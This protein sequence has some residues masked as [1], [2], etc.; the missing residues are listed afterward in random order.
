MPDPQ[1]KSKHAHAA[2]Q[3]QP[4]PRKVRFN[5]GSQYQVLDVVGEGAY[6]IVCSAIHRPSGRKVAI[7][8]I[9]PFDHSMFCLRTLREL[10]LLKFL[11]ESG[12]SENYEP[13]VAI[14][15][16]ISILDIIRPPSLEAFKEVYLIQEL[17]ETDMHRVIRTQDLSDDHAQ[18]FIY[19]TLRALKALHS[20][21]VIHRDLK[22]SNLLLNA[23]CDLKVCDFGLARSVKTAE[24]S[25]TETGFMTEYVAT[26]WYRAPEIMLTFKQYTKAI[27]VWSV[28]CIL[29][30]ML[31][32]KPLF[33]GRD[34]HHQLTLILD[35]LGTPTLDEFYAIT[36]RRSR[37]YI[38]ALPFRKKRPFAAL[39]PNANPLAIDFLTKT[40]TFDP[41]KRITVE[42]AL[43]HPYLEAYHDPEDEPEAPP[44]D[45]EFFE[46][47]LHKDDISPPVASGPSYP[48]ALPKFQQ[49]TSSS[50]FSLNINS[51]AYNYNFKGK[52]NAFFSQHKGEKKTLEKHPP[53]NGKITSQRRKLISDNIKVMK[54]PV[55]EKGISCRLYR[56]KARRASTSFPPIPPAFWLDGLVEQKVKDG[57]EVVR[58]SLRY[59]FSDSR[60]HPVSF[61]R[62]ALVANKY[63]FQLVTLGLDHHYLWSTVNWTDEN[64]IERLYSYVNIIV[65]EARRQRPESIPTLLKVIEDK[66]KP[67]GVFMAEV[68]ED[69]YRLLPSFCGRGNGRKPFV[70][71]GVSM[72][73]K[74]IRAFKYAWYGKTQLDRER[75]SLETLKD[76]PGVVRIDS[77]L[78]QRVLEDNKTDIPG[79]D[80]DEESIRMRSLLV[81]RTVGY[82]CAL[83]NQC[84]SSWRQCTIFSK[85]FVSLHKRRISCIAISVGA[86]FCENDWKVRIALADFDHSV[87]LE[88]YDKYELKNATGTPMF[89]AEDVLSVRK[90]KAMA[91]FSRISR[92]VLGQALDD[93]VD[94]YA[95]HHEKQEWDKFYEK[96]TALRW[97][98][99]P[100]ED[101]DNALL[102]SFRH[103][104]V[105][106][107]ESVVYLCLLFFNRL[108][109]F[110]EY[111]ERSEIGSLEENRG[112]L[113]EIFAGRRC[114]RPTV[115]F[116][117]PDRTSIATG[118]RFEPAYNMLK[119]M[120]SYVSFPWYNV[121]ETGRRERYEFHLHDFMQRLILKEIRRLRSS[122][123]PIFIEENPL[124]ITMPYTVPTY[125]RYAYS[126]SSFSR[127]SESV[128]EVRKK[129]KNGAS[130]LYKGRGCSTVQE[131]FSARA[132][133]VQNDTENGMMNLT[134]GREKNGLSISSTPNTLV[135]PVDRPKEMP[136]RDKEMFH[137]PTGTFW[138]IYWWKARERLWVTAER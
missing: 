12:V 55:K 93:C 18:Y 138:E 57:K 5:V 23:N 110:D 46:F 135:L 62:H 87:D 64:W 70:A 77:S 1:Q 117:L 123:D 63:H 81:L 126:S 89:M 37:D 83:A 124:P 68:G 102:Q 3:G 118:Q 88:K 47:D 60:H 43:A 16:I 52:Y 115:R 34:Y 105:H 45:P 19:Q 112:K 35:V 44:L 25:G 103:G 86:M 119:A 33:P 130:C 56:D 136:E 98:I 61:L 53:F 96:F 8:K 116:D 71:L 21:D 122:G 92:T 73:G 131:I 104:A 120:L 114:G 2:S 32:G 51:Q 24:P 10:K 132:R 106:D 99:E 4:A 69:K 28:G 75:T 39:F 94:K 97:K 111:I 7:K 59:L 29:A 14:A 65:Q 90:S 22:P 95:D 113:F 101:N 85:C 40:L 129:L 67:I 134:C 74:K 9:A 50:I 82:P 49:L 80:L 79:I 13:H 58:Q 27:D 84:K 76:A 26:R 17:M 38:R 128:E 30:E 41:K 15:Q 109:P 125:L 31:S 66:T 20:A 6:G 78:S 91:P 121:A 137:D 108:W 36:T 127:S 48:Q 72:S 133:H 107:A 100:E 11:S 54:S 42:E